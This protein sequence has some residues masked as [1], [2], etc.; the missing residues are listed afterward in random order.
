MNTNKNH[1]MHWILSGW[2][3]FPGYICYFIGLYRNYSRDSRFHA[4]FGL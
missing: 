2:N 1:K 4:W 3:C